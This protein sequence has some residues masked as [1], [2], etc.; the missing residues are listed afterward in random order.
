MYDIIIENGNTTKRLLTGLSY[1]EACFFCDFFKW[2]YT[3]ENGD[4]WDL[5]AVEA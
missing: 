5:D 1:S 3:D 2:S 4:T